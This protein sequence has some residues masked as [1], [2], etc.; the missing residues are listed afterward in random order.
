MNGYGTASLDESYDW[1]DD[2]IDLCEGLDEDEQFELE[3]ALYDA[4]SYEIS[5]VENLSNGDEVTITVLTIALYGL[6]TALLN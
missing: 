6:A 4:V 1:I 5:P 2:A 3:L